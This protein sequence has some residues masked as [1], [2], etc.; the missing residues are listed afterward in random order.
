MKKCECASGDGSVLTTQPEIT[1][2]VS[3]GVTKESG[4]F[5]GGHESSAQFTTKVS[6]GVT[7]E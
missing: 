4:V 3:D 6:D 5:A 7:K 1:T 2:K